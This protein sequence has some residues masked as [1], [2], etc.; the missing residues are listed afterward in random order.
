MQRHTISRS[1]RIVDAVVVGVAIASTLLAVTASPATSDSI[2]TAHPTPQHLVTQSPAGGYVI[3]PPR[4]GTSQRGLVAAAEPIKR[5]AEN[6][7]GNFRVTCMYSHMNYDDPILYPRRANRAHLH[8]FFGNTRAN[9]NSTGRSLLRSGDSTCDGGT[10]NRSSYW[11]PS[12]V[13]PQGRAVAPSY[14]MIYYKSGFQGVEPAEVVSELPNGLAMIAGN[15][16]AT[17]SQGEPSYNRRV[18]WTCVSAGYTTRSASIG[19][20]AAGDELMAEIQ[21][22]QCWDGVRLSAVDQSHVAYGTYG[23]GCPSTHPVA[24]PSISFNVHWKVPAG[25]TTGWRLSSD[26]YSG[27]PGGYSL[28]G[29]VILAWDPETA[30]TWLNNCTRQNAD[31]NVGQVTDTQRLLPFATYD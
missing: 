6:I 22:P 25:G 17:A 21:F 13:D 5:P 19:N 16:K 11:V 23:V 1:R 18:D 12:I 14:N 10:L 8:T 24:L 3:P 27:G 28:H 15:A 2:H 9:A 26:M 29:D 4:A 20:C 31:C 7:G 30:R